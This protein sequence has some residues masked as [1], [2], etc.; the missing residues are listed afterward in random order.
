MADPSFFTTPT[1]IAV[2]AAGSSLVG[3]LLGSGISS[4]TLRATH[5]QRIAADEGLA[6]RKFDFDRQLASRKAEVEA[7]LA[8]RKFKYDRD[9]HD[10][11]RRMELAEQALI[12][13]YEVRDAFV[14]ARSPGSFGGEGD[15]RK[16]AAGESKTQQEQRNTY[17]IPIE[18]LTRDKELFAK[19]QSL[20]YV[21]AA[22]FGEAAI[23]P[24]KAI[25]GVHN[26]I[27]SSASLLI[28][29]TPDSDDIGGLFERS[30]PSLLNTV[31][32]GM[33]DRPDD[34]DRRIDQAFKEV[35]KI[36]LPV[37]SRTPAQ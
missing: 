35:E 36:C 11:K 1:G 29:L 24:F 21:F 6:E 32:W 30:S 20:R 4:L 23:E 13:F 37:L 7:D 12:A 34:I 17:F 26:E 8:E 25:W 31:G 16:P 28:R 18:R 19:L 22:H 3:A 2:I 27:I 15:T 14:W 10:H 9:L 5:R 33:A